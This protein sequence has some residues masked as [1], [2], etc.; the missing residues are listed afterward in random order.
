[1]K[2][3][4][5]VDLQNDFM[6][7]GALAVKGGNEVVPVA[8]RLS[9]SCKFD[10]IV[11]TQDWHPSGHKSFASSSGEPVGTMGELNGKP[12]IWWPD[13]CVW[14][15]PGAEFH[16]NLMTGRA[17]LI[18]RKGMDRKVDSYSAFYDNDGSSVGLGGYLR[19]RNVGEVYVCGLATDYCVKFTALDAVKLGF[20]TRLFE[21][22]CRPVNVNPNDGN[23]AIEE[24]KTA[25]I[26]ILHSD[27]FTKIK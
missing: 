19:D 1:M 13:H 8:N 16:K 23:K 25:G 3:L 20:N 21:D 15:T 24:M 11:L 14:G 2:A 12:Q 5:I 10:L 18:I 22:G 26:E 27:V 17:N 7:G 4:I 6:P 9:S